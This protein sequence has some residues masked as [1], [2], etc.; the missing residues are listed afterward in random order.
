MR[1]FPGHER[2]SRARVSSSAPLLA[3]ILALPEA[4]SICSVASVLARECSQ[5]SR[6]VSGWG[7]SLGRGA[8]MATAGAGAAGTGGRNAPL[9][10]HLTAEILRS[11]ALED[12]ELRVVA[13]EAGFSRSISWGR[14]QRPG[15]AFAGFLAFIKPGRIQIL[16]ESELNYLDT[17]PLDVRRERISLICALPV[18]AF[19]VT[20]GQEVPLELVGECRAR[21]QSRFGGRLE[22]FSHVELVLHQGRSDLDTVTGAW[23]WWGIGAIAVGL[24]L[25]VG[26]LVGGE[27]ARNSLIALGLGILT[28]AGLAAA[29]VLDRRDVA[30]AP[31]HV[32]GAAELPQA[33]A[34]LDVA[35]PDGVDDLLVLETNVDDLDPRRALAA[36]GALCV[37]GSPLAEARSPSRILFSPP[38]SKF[39]TNWTAT[40]AL[41]GHLGSGGLHP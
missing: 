40:R 6:L 20:K 26:A 25:G 28:H 37:R 14:I 34:G 31:H 15:L 11:P 24:G 30:A 3:S 36:S 17:M 29:L 27:L 12:L 16:G 8:G 38:S 1:I 7:A 19:V 41:P 22:P 21:R 9:T 5:P 33:A 23:N 18:S 4:N 39:T 32:F 2:T 35:A 13:G 10:A